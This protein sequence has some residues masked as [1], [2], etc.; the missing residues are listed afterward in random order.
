[1]FIYYSNFQLNVTFL[2]AGIFNAKRNTLGNIVL[3]WY[4]LNVWFEGM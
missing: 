2:L 3:C 4:T 1:M